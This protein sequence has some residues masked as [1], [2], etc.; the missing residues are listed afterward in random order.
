VWGREPSPAR[1]A[2][3]G[4][5]DPA[6]SAANSSTLNLPGNPAHPLPLEH[7]RRRDPSCLRRRRQTI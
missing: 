2:Q 5:F 4:A 1:R 7:R 6:R 3:F